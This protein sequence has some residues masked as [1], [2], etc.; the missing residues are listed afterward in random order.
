MRGITL[1]LGHSSHVEVALEGGKCH[2]TSDNSSIVTHCKGSVSSD[3]ELATLYILASADMD[4]M[5]A[6]RWILQFRTSGGS[7]VPE[8]CVVKQPMIF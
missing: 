4:A 5:S 8:A 7:R 2:G 6:I 1:S 3:S